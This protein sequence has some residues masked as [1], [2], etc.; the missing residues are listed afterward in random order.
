VYLVARSRK[1]PDLDFGSFLRRSRR[2]TYQIRMAWG[3]LHE[4]RPE[5]ESASKLRGQWVICIHRKDLTPDLQRQWAQRI[6]IEEK[7]ARTYRLSLRGLWR[8]EE[9]HA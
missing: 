5:P 1:G 8:L 6:R 2:R 4:R 3:I 9:S 7:I